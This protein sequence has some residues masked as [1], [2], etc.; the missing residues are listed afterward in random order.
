[1]GWLNKGV[2]RNSVAMLLAE[3]VM[4][5]MNSG[6]NASSIRQPL[7]NVLGFVRFASWF[8]GARA[9]A[10]SGVPTGYAI[11]CDLKIPSI[12]EKKPDHD[13]N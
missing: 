6:F 5:P 1:M 10:A 11:I 8:L 9:S 4:V 3:S 2:R 7:Q 12:R 13:T